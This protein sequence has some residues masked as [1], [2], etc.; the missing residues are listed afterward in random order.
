MP[1]KHNV[2]F[3]LTAALPAVLYMAF[4][5]VISLIQYLRLS[6]RNWLIWLN[7]ENGIDFTAHVVLFGGGNQQ[8]ISLANDIVSKDCWLDI[9][10]AVVWPMFT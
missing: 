8:N 6:R 10:H 3:K 2:I 4:L 7:Q 5:P 1:L 9:Y